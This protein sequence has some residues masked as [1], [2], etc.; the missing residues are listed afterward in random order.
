ME[1]QEPFYRGS[2]AVLDR[3]F[4]RAKCTKADLFITN[5]IHCHPPGDRDPYPH[6]TQNCAEFLRTELHD[7]VRPGVV[8]GVGKFARQA[9]LRL[10]PKPIAREINW[11]FRIPRSRKADPPNLT[12]LVF[13]PHPY[14][15]MT[16]PALDREL[17]ERRLARAIEWGFTR[18]Q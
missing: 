15:I 12:Y 6:E 4:I 5:S 17:Y 3:V 10:Y 2:G 8:I 16:R 9:V 13:P 14:H 18:S 7:I 11:P 1:A